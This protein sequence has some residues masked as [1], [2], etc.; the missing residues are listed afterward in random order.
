MKVLINTCFGGF[1]VTEELVAEFNAIK[2]GQDPTWEDICE[3]ETEYWRT[4]PDL[5]QLVERYQQEGK[6]CNGEYA[7]LQV[8]DI[9]PGWES[10]W[11]VHEYDGREVLCYVGSQQFQTQ[12]TEAAANTRAALSAIRDAKNGSTRDDEHVELLL[13]LKRIEALI[14]DP[15]ADT[16]KRPKYRL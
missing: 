2:R 5:I 15:P 1:E 16:P 6:V 14:D 11:R 3:C 7:Q 4:D 10:S 8:R 12:V 13:F 9:R